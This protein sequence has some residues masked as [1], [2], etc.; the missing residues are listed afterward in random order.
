[1]VEERKARAKS[2]SFYDDDLTLIERA[3]LDSG[4]QNESAMLRQMIRFWW[5]AHYP[6]TLPHFSPCE[7]SNFSGNGQDGAQ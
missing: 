7:S 2:F 5:E 3:S 1:M 6:T 4:A